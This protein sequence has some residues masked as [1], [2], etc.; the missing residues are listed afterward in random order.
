[1]KAIPQR[2][3][4]TDGA[5]RPTRGSSRR[6]AGVVVFVAI[7]FPAALFGMAL[8][9]DHG[10]ILLAARQ[11]ADIADSVVMAA[12]SAR[13]DNGDNLDQSESVIRA[14]ATFSRAKGVGMLSPNVDATMRT[15]D[16][17]FSSDGRSVSVTVR[18]EV[19]SLPLMKVFFP[20][21]RAIG[22]T[23][24]RTARVCIAEFDSRPCAY[25]V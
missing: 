24:T 25:P 6:G 4:R 3:L 23:A 9:V 13:T 16:I 20:E 17:V 11:S 19:S 1:M 10:R 5:R 21:L 2:L 8:T 12:A 14:L 22:G 18:W 15:A 7:L